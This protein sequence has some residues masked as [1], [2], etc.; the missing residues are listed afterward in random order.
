[1]TVYP[2]WLQTH[3]V[4]QADPE[5]SAIDIPA[6]NSKSQAHATM[7]GSKQNLWMLTEA[8]EKL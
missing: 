5:F 3:Y 4:D 7:P 1:M 2:G 8:T 6:S